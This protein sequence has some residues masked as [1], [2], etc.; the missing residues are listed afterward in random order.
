MS[1]QQRKSTEDLTPR[2]VLVASPHVGGTPYGRQVVLL[3]QHS[4]RGSVGAVLNGQ[5]QDTLRRVRGRM[6]DPARRRGAAHPQDVAVPVGLYQWGPGQLDAEL[7]QGVWLASPA[8]LDDVLGDHRDLW[9]NLVREI[10]RTVLHDALK[11][12]HIPTNPTVN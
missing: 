4:P 1:I 8:K 10:G 9:I 7:K 5:L 2:H 11:I 6:M 3:L 12:K